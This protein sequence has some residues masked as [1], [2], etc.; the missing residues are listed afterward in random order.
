MRAREDRGGNHGVSARGGCGSCATA[1]RDP[2]PGWSFKKERVV[3]GAGQWASGARTVRSGPRVSEGALRERSRGSRSEVEEGKW[4]EGTDRR[5]LL[6]RPRRAHGSEVPGVLGWAPRVWA[7]RGIRP[8]KRG[9]GVGRV[10][11]WCGVLLGRGKGLGS[12]NRNWPWA[13]FWA[14]LSSWALGWL[15]EGS[16]LGFV[17]L[18]LFYF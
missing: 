13:V 10:L 5:A 16:G 9:R 4:S 11:G 18:S 2:S 15:G 7:A 3:G 12:G 14:G 1:L 8:G 6:V 17:F